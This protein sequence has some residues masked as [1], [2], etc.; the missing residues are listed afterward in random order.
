MR[1]ESAAEFRRRR[2][3]ELILQGEPR[4]V[5][6]RILGVCPH[7]LSVWIQQFQEGNI[8]KTRKPTGRPRRLSATQLEQL[9]ELL[10]Q[11]PTPNGWE[12]NLWTTVRVREIIK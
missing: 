7:S 4:M 10:A 2:A 1:S 6:S 5:V 3:V 8:L 9:R 12:N 11:G